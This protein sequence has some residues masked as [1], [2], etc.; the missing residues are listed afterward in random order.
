MNLSVTLTEKD[1]GAWLTE[2]KGRTQS[3]QVRA[4]V[5]VNSDPVLLSWDIGKS[6]LEKQQ[7]EGW[8]TRVIDRLAADLRAA[9]PSMKGFSPRNLKYMRAF[10]DAW[11]DAEFV[12][13]VLALLPWFHNRTVLNKVRDPA[14][15]GL[16][17]TRLRHEPV[18]ADWRRQVA[19]QERFAVT[20]AAMASLL[21]KEE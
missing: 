12:Q 15:L 7:L 19:Q 10:A 20:E 21:T 18:C 8:G 13:G 9:F 2:S 6:I 5:A 4:A 14:A 1:Y 16:T 17:V 3:A 11:P